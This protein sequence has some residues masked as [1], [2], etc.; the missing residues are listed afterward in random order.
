MAVIK[1]VLIIEKINI[2]G[3]FLGLMCAVKYSFAIQS[4]TALPF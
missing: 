3:F 1:V 4:Q 2:P